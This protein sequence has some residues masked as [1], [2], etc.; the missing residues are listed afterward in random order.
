MVEKPRQAI[1]RVRRNINVSLNCSISRCIVK[2]SAG[3]QASSALQELLSCR[4]N[5]CK[6]LQ[7]Y[8]VHCPVN[9]YIGIMF[10]TCISALDYRFPRAT[11][12]FSPCF[13]HAS[14]CPIIIST[15]NCSLQMLR[16][17]CRCSCSCSICMRFYA[18]QGSAFVLS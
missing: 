18:L 7:S 15:D 8:D 16:R 6:Y 3:K 12:F 11:P 2:F 13:T 9:V 4:N 1:F 14:R 17:T 10:H 5:S